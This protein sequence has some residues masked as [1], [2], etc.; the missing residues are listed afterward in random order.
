MAE[1]ATA[2]AA[3]AAGHGSMSGGYYD[4]TSY[5]GGY[6]GTPTFYDAAMYSGRIPTRWVRVRPALEGEGYYEMNGIDAGHPAACR[7][8][9]N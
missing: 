4:A 9:P 8:T 7:P 3:T 6:G 1:G 5:A 2:A